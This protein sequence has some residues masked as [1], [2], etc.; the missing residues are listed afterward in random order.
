MIALVS[1]TPPRTAVARHDART[2]PS[3]LAY[4]DT[5]ACAACALADAAARR[6]QQAVR[7]R[8]C[9]RIPLVLRIFH[10]EMGMV[11]VRAE[12][13]LMSSRSYFDTWVVDRTWWRPCCSVGYCKQMLS[14]Q[15][16]AARED[17]PCDWCWLKVAEWS[18]P[19]DTVDR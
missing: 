6:I 2:S 3:L 12:M 1:R 14:V 15:F 11:N 8:F 17:A 13:A 4:L 5:R 10:D 16:Y 7:N 9:R 18:A 19:M